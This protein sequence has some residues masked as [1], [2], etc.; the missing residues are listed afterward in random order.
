MKKLSFDL[1][2]LVFILDLNSSRLFLVDCIGYFLS[3][4]VLLNP[5]RVEDVLRLDEDVIDLFQSSAL[6]LWV[7]EVED[8]E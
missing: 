6:G 3:R 2:T 1:F 4:H 8:P 5:N 7:E